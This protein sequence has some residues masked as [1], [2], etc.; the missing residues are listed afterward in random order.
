MLIG[1]KIASRLG[2]RQKGKQPGEYRLHRQN[3]LAK[4]GLMC[5]QI[6]TQNLREKV[7]EYLITFHRPA[8]SHLNMPLP[9]YIALITAYSP[10]SK[11]ILSYFME[12]DY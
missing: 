9:I 8:G 4:C 6:I 10:G 1:N 5:M 11:F 12:Y 2:R 7:I 3:K